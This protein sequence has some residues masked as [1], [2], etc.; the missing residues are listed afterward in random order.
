MKKRPLGSSQLELSV[1]GLGTMTFGAEADEATSHAILDHYTEAGG[2]FVDTADVYSRGVS[3][4][5]IGR[6]LARTSVEGIV[7]AT[8][9][10]FPMGDGP[11]DVGAGRKHLVK[12]LDASLGRLGVETIDLYQIH[13]WD[14]DTPLE[15]T[16][17]TLS[18]FVTAGKVRHVGV[19]NFLGWH[20]ERA[21][22]LAD[23]NDWPRVVSL[24]PQYSLLAREIELDVLPLALELGVGILPW[25][26]LGGGWLTGKY[27][28]SQRPT[29]ATRLGENPTRGV[30]AYDLRNNQQ[31]WDV[32]DAVEKIA[33][34]HD[35]VMSQVA[36]NW[37]RARPGVTSVLLGCRN[38]TQLDQ[39]LGCLEWDLADS[40]MDELNRVSAP[41]IPAYPHGFLETL[42]NVGSWS[43]LA[44]RAEPPL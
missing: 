28:A 36:L 34:D 44:T 13:A 37:L 6:W 18:D 22:Q 12:A 15:E 30:E 35:V 7:L 43:D 5:I 42:A 11:D 23:R 31:T 4:E 38:V 25:S 20:L 41:G 9:A 10:R 16:L 29:G 32:V 3:E 1:L 33:G 14:P 39:N 21:T 24:Q 40:E 8:K 26:P 27:T 19:S 2:R 17:E